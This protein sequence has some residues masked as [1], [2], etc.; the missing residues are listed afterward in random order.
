[1]TTHK[2][3]QPL[4]IIKGVREATRTRLRAQALVWQIKQIAVKA[5]TADAL[6]LAQLRLKLDAYTR[7]LNK[8]LPD[9]KAVEHSG[10]AKPAVVGSKPL[11]VEEWEAAHCVGAPAGAATQPH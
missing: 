2:G 5:D 8:C 7:L 6:Q 3:G 11:T 1:M 9:L 4:K 10:D